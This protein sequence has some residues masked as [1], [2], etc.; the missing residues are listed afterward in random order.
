MAEMDASQAR[1]TSVMEDPSAQAVAR[2]YADAFLDAAGDEAA[3]SLE[4]FQSFLSDVLQPNPDFASVL[5]SGIFSRDEKNGLIDRVVAPSASARFT[6]FLHVL[7]HHDRLDLL[8]AIYEE[9]VI[10]HELRQGRRR[11]QIRSASPLS[12]EALER[13][14]TRLNEAFPFE[15][16]LMP[17]VDPALLGGIVIQVGD[18]VYDSS[19]RNRM[20]QLRDSL[21][22]RT[23][24][25]IQSGR[26][27]FSYPEG[28]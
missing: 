14:R 25:E 9:A 19:L 12:D 5:Y 11:V 22:Q 8:P 20:K 6:N 2:V 16:I 1:V 18:T 28:D 26:D 10:Q 15:P 24:H 21:R 7:V 4:E 3:D 13:V 27:R 23:L 17:T